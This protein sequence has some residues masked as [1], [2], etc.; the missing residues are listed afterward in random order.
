MGIINS[1]PA[2][3]SHREDIEMTMSGEVKEA[4]KTLEIPTGLD[5]L[6]RD[7]NNINSHLKVC[8]I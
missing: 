5:L 1:S 2:P 3:R 6:Y 7:P 4:E 8:Y